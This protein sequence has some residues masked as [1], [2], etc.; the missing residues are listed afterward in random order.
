MACD[1]A[2]TSY[3]PSIA[4]VAIFSPRITPQHR[5]V[6]SDRALT[7]LQNSWQFLRESHPLFDRLTR[8]RKTQK[9]ALS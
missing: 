9:V 7:S 3:R 1:G 4:L 2:N 6:A 5:P 8:E